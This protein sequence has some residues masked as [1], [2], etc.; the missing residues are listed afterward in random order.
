MID[1]GGGSE[2]EI[3]VIIGEFQVP[4]SLISVIAAWKNLIKQWLD[5]FLITAHRE[6]LWKLGDLIKIE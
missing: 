6:S 4:I 5:P 2:H 1:I 3:A